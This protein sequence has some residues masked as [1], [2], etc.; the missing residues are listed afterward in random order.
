MVSTLVAAVPSHANTALPSPPILTANVVQQS[1]S[2]VLARRVLVTGPWK[3]SQRWESWGFRMSQFKTMQG[4]NTDC[5][6]NFSISLPLAHIPGSYVLT[7]SLQLRSTPS[8][9]NSFS[10]RHPSYLGVS[11]VL[12]VHHPFIIACCK[13]D[14]ITVW[15]MLQ[16]GE[17]CL[18]DMTLRGETP[19]RVGE[20]SGTV[21][22]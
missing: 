19:M 7:G 22:F 8:C 14:A 18:T 15:M 6:I 4:H 16:S 10:F 21:S 2:K 1:K 11:R 12:D 17:G 9:R 13:G 5:T 3:T 20:K